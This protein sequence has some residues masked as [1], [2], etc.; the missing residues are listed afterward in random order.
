[1]VIEKSENIGELINKIKKFKDPNKKVKLVLRINVC[2]KE[3][4]KLKK[5]LEGKIITGVL[6]ERELPEFCE[7]YDTI[8]EEA[9]NQ[10]Q[11]KSK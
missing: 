7:Q 10:Q 6:M 2:D 1:M 4:Y 5:E 8:I 9:Q 11:G 3:Y